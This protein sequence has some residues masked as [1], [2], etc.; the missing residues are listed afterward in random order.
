MLFLILHLLSLELYSERGQL[1]LVT[2]LDLSCLLNVLVFHVLNIVLQLI[3][4]QFVV[5]V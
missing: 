4:D 5:L 2:V 1:N 3:D